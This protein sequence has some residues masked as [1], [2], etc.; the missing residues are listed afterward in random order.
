M[1]DEAEMLLEETLDH[2]TLEITCAVIIGQLG[3][4]VTEDEESA[5]DGYYIVEWTADPFICPDTG[6]WKYTNAIYYDP[7]KRAKR[8]YTRNIHPD[9]ILMSHVVMADVKVKPLSESN[10]LPTNYKSK[11][12]EEEKGYNK[13][14]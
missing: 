13:D 5:P 10:P 2:K 7:V 11:I 4:V 12:E 6:K 9:V 1:D 14:Q 3:A 8:W